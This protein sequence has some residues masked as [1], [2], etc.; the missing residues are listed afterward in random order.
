MAIYPFVEPAGLVLQRNHGDPQCEAGGQYRRR[1]DNHCPSRPHLAGELPPSTYVL[2]GLETTAI[3]TAV[4]DIL[5]GGEEGSKKRA[6]RLRVRL[7][8]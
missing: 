6:R 3:R 4:C 8:R 1:S 2:G 7:E 5:E